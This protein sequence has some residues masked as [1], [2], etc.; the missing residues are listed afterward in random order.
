MWPFA[1]GQ[2]LGRAG[3]RNGEGKSPCVQR[4]PP[5]DTMLPRLG[6]HVPSP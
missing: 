2:S 1:K 6:P 5:P 4:Q 3:E